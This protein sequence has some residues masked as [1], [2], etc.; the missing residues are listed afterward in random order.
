VYDAY[1][2]NQEGRPP[3]NVHNGSAGPGTEVGTGSELHTGKG[4]VDSVNVH[5]VHVIS[6]S[7]V[8]TKVIE[9][10]LV[11]EKE[12][13]F[14]FTLHR[15]EDGENTGGDRTGTIIVPPGSTHGS[16]SITF[17]NLPRGTYIVTEAVSD[18]YALKQILVASAT[19]CQSTPAIGETAPEVTFVMGN[20]VAGMNV[21]GYKAP[22]DRFTS[23]VDPV[24]GVYGQAV[25]TNGPKIFTG[26]IPV[27]KNW[28]DGPEIHTSDA[29]YLLLLK[30]GIPVLDNEGYA[31]LLRLDASNNW[32]GVFTVV[33]ADK[34]DSVTNY[35]YAVREVTQVSIEPLYTWSSAVLENDGTTLL[36]YERAL[37]DG[38]LG[39]FG[40]R[41]YVVRY[42][43][44]EDDSWIVTNLHAVELPKTGGMGT[45]PIYTFGVLLTT[46]A[47]F[48]AGYD[49]RRKQRRE[50]VE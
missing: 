31:R 17:S 3:G 35:D 34:D 28:D 50:A 13:V 25:F 37:E 7:I 47:A 21:I 12:Q 19:N 48:V 24:N 44:T 23:Y 11:S 49:R 2:L 42:E 39:A 18:D 22:S 26:E 10:S 20:N 29:V 27:E 40:G 41:S 36:Y 5:K 8:I 9:E 33:L 6:G 45:A 43:K 14:T 32:Q 4:T 1:R 15:V 16:A 30:D 46:A 38:Q